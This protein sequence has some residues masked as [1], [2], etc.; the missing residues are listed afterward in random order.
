MDKV[1]MKFIVNFLLLE[2]ANYFEKF[3]IKKVC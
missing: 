1:E 3:L 2:Y